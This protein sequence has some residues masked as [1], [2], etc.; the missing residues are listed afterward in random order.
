M[1]SKIVGQLDPIDYDPDFF[2]SQP[3]PIPYFDNIEL[4]VGFVEAEHQPYLDGADKVL[5]NFFGLNSKDRTGNSDIVY[6]YY[7][8][9]LK[10]G[11]TEQLDIK[12]PKDIWNF[13]TPTEIIIHW[14][15]KERFYLCVSCECEWEEEHGLQL[16]FTDGQTLTRASEQ[17]GHLTD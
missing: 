9:T 12:T 3:F 17:D 1:T 14:D 16:V 2:Y 8:E 7:S 15:E 4:K 10:F 13:V 5:E 6:H 11:Y